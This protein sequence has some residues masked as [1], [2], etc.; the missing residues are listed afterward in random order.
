M[1]LNELIRLERCK[2]IYKISKSDIKTNITICRFEEVHRYPTRNRRN[3]VI[4]PSKTNRML[5]DVVNASL[6]EF[7]RLPSNIKEINNFEK[8]VKYV[9]QEIIDSR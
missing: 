9:K 6:E 7:N 4:V 5:N 1:N 2:Y 8:F 3:F